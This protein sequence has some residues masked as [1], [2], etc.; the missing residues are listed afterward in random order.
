MY[1]LILVF[2]RITAFQLGP[3]H[4]PASPLVLRLLLP[5]YLVVNYLILLIHGAGPM[6]LL[7]I[8]A[9]FAMMCGFVWPLL[10]FAG[11]QA[12]FPQ[13]LNAMIGTDTVISFTAL[14]AA[15]SLQAE[16][17]ELAYLAMIALM[18]WHWLVSGH[19]LRN[20]LDRSWFFGLGLALLYVML[21]SQVMEA[22]FPSMALD[23]QVQMQTEIQAPESADGG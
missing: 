13:T 1:Q 8:A 2:L 21:S 3:Q 17:N 19:I 7:Q 5:I 11:K 12:R 18:I 15:A 6:G 4:V 20:A 14:P 22:L 23:S 16:P 9:D 10:Y